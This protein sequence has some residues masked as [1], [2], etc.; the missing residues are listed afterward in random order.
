[1]N[2]FSPELW[3]IQLVKRS[4][5]ETLSA[6]SS[7]ESRK[8]CVFLGG[9]TPLRQ[10]YWRAEGGTWNTLGIR[11]LLAIPPMACMEGR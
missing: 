2:I 4:K 5:V 10:L 9:F 7:S 3:Q 1:M 8:S 11:A 6:K